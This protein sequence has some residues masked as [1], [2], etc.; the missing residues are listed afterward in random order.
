MDWSGSEDEDQAGARG[1]GMLGL[2]EIVRDQAWVVYYR[3]KPFKKGGH[4]TK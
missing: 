3:L 1:E 4:G 2:L